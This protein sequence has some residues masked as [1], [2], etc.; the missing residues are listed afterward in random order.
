MIIVNNC[1][2]GKKYTCKFKHDATGLAGLQWDLAELLQVGVQKQIN[3]SDAFAIEEV[4]KLL[5]Q[6]ECIIRNY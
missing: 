6:Q 3:F 2:T 5:Y 1:I 4:V